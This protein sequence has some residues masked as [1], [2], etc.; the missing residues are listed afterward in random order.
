[1]IDSKMALSQIIFFVVGLAIGYALGRRQ[2]KA[3]SEQ[4]PQDVKE[5][6]RQCVDV[7]HLSLE[8][9]IQV[10]FVMTPLRV[11]IADRVAAALQARDDYWKAK[12]SGGRGG[13]FRVGSK[14]PLNVYEGDRP[15]FQ[16]HTPE[17][18]QRLVDLLNGGAQAQ[19][20]FPNT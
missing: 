7:P 6:A 1:M 15:L 20:R 5:I 16:A 10:N 2:E 11:L 9:R 17:E 8:D 4:S 19:A 12:L 18:A 3:M 13:P 14:V